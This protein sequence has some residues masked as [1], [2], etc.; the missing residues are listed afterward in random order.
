[1][2]FEVMFDFYHLSFL[3]FIMKFVC[4]GMIKLCLQLILKTT[5]A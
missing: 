3:S 2:S 5:K 1:M 4:T